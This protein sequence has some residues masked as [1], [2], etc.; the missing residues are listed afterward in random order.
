MTKEGLLIPR[1]PVSTYRL[2]FNRQ[3]GFSDAKKIISYLHCLGITDIY[4][5]PYFKAKVGSIH[6]YDIV[7][8]NTLNP[9]VGTKEEY[10][11]LVEELSRYAMGQILDIVPNHMCI[12]NR[13]NIWWLDVLENGPSSIYARFFDINWK[14]AKKELKDKI[15]LPILGDQYGNVLERQELR[16]AFEEGMFSIYYYDHKF[17]IEPK[18]YIYVLK[19]RIEYLKHLLTPED[20]H[21]MELLSIV[22][23]LNHLPAYTENDP[24]KIAERY[25]EKE[26]IKRRLWNIYRESHEIKCFIDENLKIF[27][28]VQGESAS[29]DLLDRLIGEQVYRL[30]FWQVAAEEINYRRFFDINSLGAVRVEDTVVFE[31][32]HKL[33]LRLIREGSVTGLRVDHIDGL[34][35]PA[36]YFRQ[37]QQ[38]CS[39]QRQL[40]FIERIGRDA[41][42]IDEQPDLETELLRQC[43]EMLSPEIQPEIQNK[44]FYIIGEKIL[45]KSEKLPE[46]WSIFS[47]TGY[48]FLN[49]VN[50]IFVLTKNVKAFNAIYNKVTRSRVNFQDIVY[51]KKKLVMQVTMSSEIN[52]LGNYLNNMSER[53]RHTRDFTLNSLTNAI[54]EI[55][56]FFPVYRTYTNSYVVKDRDRQYIE[57]AISKAKKRNPAITDSVFDFLKGVL[58]LKFPE[59]FEETDKKEW[60]DF[61]MRFQQITGPVMAKG[62]EDTVFY[63]YN[64]LVSLNEVGGTPERFGV[65]LETFHGQNIERIKFWPHALITTST[66]DSKRGEDVRARINVLSEIP[67]KWKESLTRWIK[68]NKKKKVFVDGQ[69]VPDHNEEYLFYQ[70]LIG[71]W[72]MQQLN[73]AEYDLFKQRIKDYMLKAIREATV[74]TSWINPNAK[75]EE[76]L[77]IFIENL[78]VNAADNQFLKDFR[79]FQQI[80][81][82]C[83]IYNSLSQT[84][85]KI[86]SPGVPD[87]YRGTELWDLSLVDPDNRRPV[88]YGI[89]IQ[90][91]E[92]LKMRESEIGPL[93]LTKE[94][95]AEK[96]DGRIKLYLIYKA[97]NFRRNNTELFEKGEY[98]PLEAA[99]E[100]SHNVCA[101]ARS[102]GRRNTII[103]VV[104]RFLTELIFELNSLSLNRR[105]WKDFFIIA[106]PA[107]TEARYLNIFTG[108]VART[109][110]HD[111]AAALEVSEIFA[112]SPVALLERIND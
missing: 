10:N 106:P 108:E 79:D 109:V 48:A 39:V 11:E 91:L 55:I 35:D 75:Y 98:I 51:E 70:T 40:G 33:L 92:E 4:S 38:N 44:P 74:N 1:I 23:A 87:F 54:M 62:L 30:S 81:S 46:E 73:E 9:E 111:G 7:D 14:P 59:D 65:S 37:L 31:E 58:L 19:N 17:P 85:L 107:E 94:L 96:E 57:L 101:F 90:M 41:S 34:Y 29:F 105:V 97:L 26:I 52:M 28:G 15:L 25:R 8:Y 78:M 32:V 5:S 82:E 71:A 103:V 64:R 2:Q 24:E 60:L 36:E 53:D 49:L 45:L 47:T 20:P 69:L 80:I 88:D 67:E 86:A 18:T 56:A 50:G 63:V 93:E 72:P 84:L 6:G 42:L 83:G 43:D 89:R 100:R 76:A 3:F 68:L 27:N 99:G 16:L 95:M 61:V 13:D 77:M 104:P 21:L 112:N 102:A 110:N 12:E 22:T 66:H